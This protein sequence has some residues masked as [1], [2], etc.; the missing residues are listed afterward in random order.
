MR[1]PP[2]TVQEVMY[3]QGVRSYRK[4][5]FIRIHS[6]TREMGF[7]IDQHLLI[8]LCHNPDNGPQFT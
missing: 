1:D 2:H 5:R 7:Y 3:Q 8:K 4:K 6:E